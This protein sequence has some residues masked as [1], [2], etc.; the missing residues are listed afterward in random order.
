M[1]QAASRVIFVCDSSKLMN[2]ATAKVAALEDADLLLTDEAAAPE[3]LR[4]L[5]RSGLEVMVV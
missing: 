1:I 2:V 5:R 3:T 4:A